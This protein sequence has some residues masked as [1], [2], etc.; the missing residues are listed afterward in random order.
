MG[1]PILRSMIYCGLY[2]VPVFRETT[3]ECFEKRLG[4]SAER[5]TCQGAAVLSPAYSFQSFKA[6]RAPS[7]GFRVQGTCCQ[8]LGFWNQSQVQPVQNLKTLRRL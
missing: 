5:D 3:P 7:L 4:P 6:G 2:W 1:V 8:I